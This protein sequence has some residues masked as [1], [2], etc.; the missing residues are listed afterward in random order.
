MQGISAGSC[1]RALPSMHW[2]MHL[3]HTCCGERGIMFWRHLH[4][5]QHA[6]RLVAC[7]VGKGQRKQ[8]GSLFVLCSVD[9]RMRH[10]TQEAP[11]KASPPAPAQPTGAAIVEEADVPAG[12]E[13]AQ[14]LPQRA[15][16]LGELDLEMMRTCR[17]GRS[18]CIGAPSSATRQR[19]QLT[20][21]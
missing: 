15:G 18:L 8:E 3:F 4:A 20:P 5:Q 1:L 7:G 21:P 6:A 14:E 12:A 17:G 10:G 2:H 13:G 9:R 19:G 11:A 16:P